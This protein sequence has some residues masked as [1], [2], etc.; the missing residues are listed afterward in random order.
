MFPSTAENSADVARLVER[1]REAPIGETV[2]FA[3]LDKA[4]GRPIR[5]RRYL[6]VRAM[7]RLNAETGAVFESVFGIGYRRMPIDRM[8]TVGGRARRRIKHIARRSSKRLSNAI[9]RANDLPGPV[10]LSINREI[11]VL[12]VLQVLARDGMAAKVA[13]DA[14]ETSPAPV[15]LVAQRLVEALR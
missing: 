4:I 7:D 12:G 2:S 6:L 11:A 3:E 13:A 14:T 5:S 8:A 9:G 10:A 1:L 15:A